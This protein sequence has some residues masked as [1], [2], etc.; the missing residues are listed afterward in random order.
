VERGGAGAERVIE[1]ELPVELGKVR[2]FALAVGEDNPIFFD[3][4]AAR[5]QGLP[6][7]VAPPTFTVSQ[8]W[9]VPRD[10]REERLG[11]NLDPR[12]VLHG[13]QEFVYRRLPVAG[14]LLRGKMTVARDVTKR[15]RRGGTLRVVTFESSFTDEAGDEVLTAF[16]TL[17]ETEGDPGP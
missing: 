1:F 5:V 15:G 16:Y 14:E 3:P 6:G 17:V 12:R 13:E 10:V 2:E 11:T 4:E 7:V 9:S 8:V